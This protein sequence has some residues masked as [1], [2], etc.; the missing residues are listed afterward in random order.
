VT[1]T[2]YFNRELAWL[3]FNERVLEEA[4]DPRGARCSSG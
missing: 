3:A 4:L 1:P 2:L